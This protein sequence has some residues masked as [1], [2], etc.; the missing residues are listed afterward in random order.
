VSGYFYFSVALLA[1][2]LFFPVRRMIWVLSVRRM[3]RRQGR[4][5]TGAELQGQRGRAG[6]VAVLLVVVFSWLFNLQVLGRFHG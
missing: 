6:F 4:E 5:L 1:L 2:M 3:Q